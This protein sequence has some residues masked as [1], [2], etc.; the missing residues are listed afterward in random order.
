MIGMRQVSSGPSLHFL[1]VHYIDFR[2]KAFK[3]FRGLLIKE[4]KGNDS[5]SNWSTDI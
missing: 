3:T 1:I 2:L 5:L 4:N